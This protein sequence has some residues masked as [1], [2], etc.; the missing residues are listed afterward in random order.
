MKARVRKAD[1]KGKK[2]DD[3]NNNRA[4]ERNTKRATEQQKNETTVDNINI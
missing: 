4:T 2:V 3:K 1:W